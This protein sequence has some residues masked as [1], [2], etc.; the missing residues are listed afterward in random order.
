[1]LSDEDDE[2]IDYTVKHKFLEK[3]SCFVLS[4]PQNEIQNYL[5]PFIEKFNKSEVIADLFKE[6]V[7]AEDILNTYDNFWYVWSVFK[8]KVFNICND[9]DSYWY[10]DKIVRSYIFAEIPWKATAKDWHTFKD[11][12]KR[13]FKEVSEK[14][15]HCPSCLYSISKLLNDIGTPY[16]EDGITWLSTIL[17]DKEYINK[18][19]ET[20]TIYY[21]ELFMKRYIYQNRE[22]IRTTNILKNKVLIVLNFL[23]E[24]G[25]VIGYMLRENIL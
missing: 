6:F 13:F 3:Y 12:N 17:V 4:Q 9:G 21:I 19:L 2:K 5:L 18:K 11:T 25:S 14:I 1:M 8:E 10:V 20:N 7:L 24:K 15:G 22:K 16:I 23:V